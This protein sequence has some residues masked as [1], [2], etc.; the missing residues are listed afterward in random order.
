ME[1]EGVAKDKGVWGRGGR[2]VKDRGMLERGGL[3]KIKGCG[4][5]SKR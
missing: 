5:G 3:L 4:V 2:V 1:K